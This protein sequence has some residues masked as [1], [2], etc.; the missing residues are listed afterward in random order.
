MD[1]PKPFAGSALLHPLVSGAVVLLLLNDHVFKACWP[2]WWTGKLS[3]VAGLAF[4]PLL[5]QAFWEHAEAMAR[6]RFHPSRGVLLA[7]VLL[8]GVCFAA[9]K[10]SPFAGNV[11][12]WAL[13][14]MQWPVHAL[15]AVMAGDVLP[16]VRPTAHTLDP[17]DLFTLPA[18]LAALIIGWR[19]AGSG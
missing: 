18:L 17:T 12:Q 15:R 10:L 2:S 7:C 16:A 1:A 3:D 13:G 6:Q 14:G 5:L 4:F 11:W 9:T 19:R 8:T